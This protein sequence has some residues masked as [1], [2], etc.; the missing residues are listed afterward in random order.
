MRPNEGIRA[1]AGASF[2]TYQ[3]MINTS[4]DASSTFTTNQI[5]DKYGEK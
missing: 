3:G 4:I 5:N 1:G 2:A